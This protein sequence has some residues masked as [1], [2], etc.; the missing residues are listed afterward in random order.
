[1]IIPVIPKII[2]NTNAYRFDTPNHRSANAARI[3]R[4]KR[5]DLMASLC[6]SRDFDLFLSAARLSNAPK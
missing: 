2:A 3:I 5:L 6:F 4:K 1:M